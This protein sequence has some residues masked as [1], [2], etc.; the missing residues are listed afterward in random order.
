MYKGRERERERDRPDSCLDRTYDET[1]HVLLIHAVF[2]CVTLKVAKLKPPAV[3][4][5]AGR[6]DD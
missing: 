4:A 3:V 1:C 2:N 5:D 6:M